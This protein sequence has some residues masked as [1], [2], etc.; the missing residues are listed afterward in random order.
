MSGG[1]GL[2]D[3]VTRHVFSRAPDPESGWAA[4]T[5]GRKIA[6]KCAKRQREI[7][8]GAVLRFPQLS[9]DFVA[10]GPAEPI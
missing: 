3:V 6:A 1:R 7:L 5:Q 9:P 2:P 4:V 10:I 8:A